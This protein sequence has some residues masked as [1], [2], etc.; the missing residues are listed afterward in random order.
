MHF[1]LGLVCSMNAPV[2]VALDGETDPLEVRPVQCSHIVFLPSLIGKV[3][4]LPAMGPQ[5]ASGSLF[6]MWPIS[7]LF[8]CVHANSFSLNSKQAA[9]TVEHV[10]SV[11]FWLTVR[12]FKLYAGKPSFLSLPLTTLVSLTPTQFVL[13]LLQGSCAK[14]RFP[15]PSEG[16]C[17]MAGKMRLMK[18]NG[19]HGYADV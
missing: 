16:T 9:L 2:M 1:Y 5:A 4:V 10:S 12:P 13:R 11:L 19:L 17:Q 15:S 7:C 6:F 8:S 14:R 18:K 3:F